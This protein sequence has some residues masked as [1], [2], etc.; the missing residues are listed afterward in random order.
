[1]S[2]PSE[3]LWNIFDL[4]PEGRGRDWEEQLAYPCRTSSPALR[5]GPPAVRHD[6][7]VASA[8]ILPA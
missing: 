8:A 7:L 4:V 2:A 5:A 3:P 6:L 1:M